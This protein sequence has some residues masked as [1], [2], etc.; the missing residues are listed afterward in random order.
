MSKVPTT[1]GVHRVVLAVLAVLLGG[2]ATF[3]SA[4]DASWP[5]PKP[6]STQE[7]SSLVAASASIRSAPAQLVPPLVQAAADTPAVYFPATTVSCIGTDRCAFG[8]V[9]SHRVI[10]LLGDSHARM[11]LPALVPEARRLK[12]RLVLEWLPAC[13]TSAVAVLE[14]A[15][16]RPYYWCSKFR[17]EA[18]ADVRRIK[19]LLVLLTDRTAGVHDTSGHPIPHSLWRRGEE[20]MIGALR[21]TTTRVAIIG[22]ITRFTLP[23]PACLGAYSSDIQR[24]SVSDPNQSFTSHIAD[25]KAA[26]RATGTAYIDPDR[27]LCRRT[28]SAII[29]HMVAYYDAQHISATYAE[30]LSTVMGYQLERLVPR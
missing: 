20:A 3:T 27:W 13:P 26:A 21:T 29:G 15:T 16:G 7:I 17:N 22:D 23:L 1:R 24:C 6:G 2:S 30:F 14:P 10:L 11:W 9:S 18:V 28:C 19:P 5:L 25:E 12:L 8:D 4:A